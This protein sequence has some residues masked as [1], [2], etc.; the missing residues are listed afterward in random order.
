M[1]VGMRP[2]PLISQNQPSQATQVAGDGSFSFAPLPAAKY[3]VY[4]IPMLNPNN[5]GLLGG[6]PTMPKALMAL[7]PYVKSVQVGGRD[8]LDSYR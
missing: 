1:A 8:V 5:P 4:V 7:N 2:D 6:M 3:R